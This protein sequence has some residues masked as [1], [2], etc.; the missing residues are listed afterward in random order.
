[1]TQVADLVRAWTQLID[2]LPASHRA[3][4]TASQ[5]VTVHENTAIVAVPDDFTRSQLESRLRPRLEHGLSELLW[6]SLRLAVPGDNTLARPDV[7]PPPD[8][9]ADDG[10]S[11]SDVAPLIRD[12]AP[13]VPDASVQR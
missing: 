8:R 6:Q 13:A 10:L 5:P 1:M 4:V 9:H 3:W 7:A 12:E 11:R 2:E